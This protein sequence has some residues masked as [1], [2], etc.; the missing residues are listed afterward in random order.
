M[1]HTLHHHSNDYVDITFNLLRNGR[2]ELKYIEKDG[3][4]PNRREIFDIGPARDLWNR[5][6]NDGFRKVRQ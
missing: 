1:I 3:S 4:S 5:Y 6:V 2:V